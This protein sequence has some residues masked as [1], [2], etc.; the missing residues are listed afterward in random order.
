MIESNP[1][2]SRLSQTVQP[3]RASPP[4][5]PAAAPAQSSSLDTRKD[6]QL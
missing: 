2:K 3:I 5:P 1:P 6:A 4:G